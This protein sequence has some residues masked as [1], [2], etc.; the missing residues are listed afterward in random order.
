M[1][2]LKLIGLD[3]A[4]LDV[5]S[6]HMQDAVFKVGDIDY[7]PRHRQF[8]LTGN[9]F[10]WEAADKRRKSFER[11]RSVLHFARVDRVR[12]AGIDRTRPDDV[13]SLLSIRFEPDPTPPSG[14]IELI[15][16]GDASIV[17]DVECIEMQL[18]DQGGA[19]E[20]RFRP[21]HPLSD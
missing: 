1:D 8:V 6:A 19:W 17:L 2:H 20:T 13:L 14:E 5:I 10:V 15:F 11:R 3:E 16:A 21:K 12:T 4:D 7:S 18:A 9:R